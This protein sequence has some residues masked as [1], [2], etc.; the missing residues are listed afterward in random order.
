MTSWIAWAATGSASP[1]ATSMPEELRRRSAP[2]GLGHAH[3]LV[4]RLGAE[5]WQQVREVQ[6]SVVVAPWKQIRWA[7]SADP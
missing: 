3:A 7:S 1:S 5:E 2:G 6:C 4:D